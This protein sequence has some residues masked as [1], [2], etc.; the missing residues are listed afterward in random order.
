MITAELIERVAKIPF[1]TLYTLYL[2]MIEKKGRQQVELDA[3]LT[4]LTG[5]SLDKLSQLRQDE[6]LSTKQFLEEAPQINPHIWEMRGSICG[7]KLQEI[8]SPFMRQ[9]R[10]MD[11][12]ID[13]LAKGKS[14]DKLVKA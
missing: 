3:I 13:D 6:R 8:S 9:V 4:W 1:A 7:Y 5:Y 2:N 10:C 11:K 12:L 14:L